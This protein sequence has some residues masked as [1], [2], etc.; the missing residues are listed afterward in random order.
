MEAL[1]PSEA[2]I[3]FAPI[4]ALSTL[5]IIPAAIAQRKGYNFWLAYGFG[6]VIW[7]VTM[8][9]VILLPAKEG[10]IARP[11]TTFRRCSRCGEDNDL[12]SRSCARCGTMLSR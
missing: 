1:T 8:V 11:A 9:V 10:S 12:N 2:L 5:A 3:L 4:F 7:I 6:V